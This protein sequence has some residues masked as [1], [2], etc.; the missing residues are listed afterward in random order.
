M[1]RRAASEPHP[2]DEDGSGGPLLDAAT[3]AGAA[4]DLAQLASDAVARRVVEVVAAG[5]DGRSLSD[6]RRIRRAA[7]RSDRI[8]RKVSK[9]TR[10]YETIR[11][12]HLDLAGVL[13]SASDRSAAE[14]LADVERSSGRLEQEA[15]MLLLAI[16]AAFPAGADVTAGA[17]R[18]PTT[19]TV[20]LR[21]PADGT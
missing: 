7:R 6:R 13:A 10:R 19:T 18:A 15:A 14:D 2:G 17:P 4:L 8:A 5:N 20:T 9:A 16:D 21:P 12:T 1:Q 11:R 3:A